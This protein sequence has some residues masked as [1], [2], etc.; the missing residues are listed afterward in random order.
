[1]PAV[2]RFALLLGGLAAIA[3]G[4]PPLVRL[5]PAPAESA[6]DSTG[7]ATTVFLIGDAG[8]SQP[9]DRVLAELTRQGKAAKRGSA[10]VFLGDNV[11]PAGI[12]PDTADAY[13][14]ARRRLLDQA[15]VAEST[16]LRVI[17]VAGN[18]DWD[19]QRKTGG[20]TIRR[21]ATLL[22]HYADSTRARVEFQPEAGCPGPAITPIG[23]RVRLVAIDTPWWLQERLQPGTSHC[24]GATEALV[25]DSLR[26]TF[27]VDESRITI[28]VGHQPIESNGEHGGYHPWIQYLLPLVPTP[29]A[30]WAWVPIGWI[31]PLGRR[32]FHHPQDLT[33]RLNGSLRS[34]LEGTFSVRAPLIYA[35]G[36]EHSLEVI[37]RGPGRYYLISGA[38]TEEHETA[39]G[40]GDSTAFSS[41]RPG[42]MR[43]DVFA[44][45]R[46]R[47]GVTVIDAERRPREI[48]QAWLKE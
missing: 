8:S 43:V 7:L 9:G 46:V 48:F 45:N 15:V 20:T 12:P 38:G 19:R 39:V 17:F 28:A 37:R 44:G 26:R 33:S 34:A 27:A 16:G 32:L 30:R 1:M 41:S 23:T 31:Y 6:L 14:E 36:H 35:A 40:R 25:L 29:M 22:R 11:Y 2:R 42:F 4:R 47:L 13:P 18:H 24:G 10:I 21:Q 3:C 5:A